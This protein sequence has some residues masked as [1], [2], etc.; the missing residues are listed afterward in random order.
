MNDVFVITSEGSAA[1]TSPHQRHQDNY[2][3]ES[4]VAVAT[5]ITQLTS[6]T[7]S[8]ESSAR[9]ATRSLCAA[10][11]ER[12]PETS[13]KQRTGRGSSSLFNSKEIAT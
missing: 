8:T 1:D 12:S 13:G 10:R 2:P 6:I 5:R 3:G 11:S 9:A 7:K 4:I